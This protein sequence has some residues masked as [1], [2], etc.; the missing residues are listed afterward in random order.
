MP[1]HLTTVE[2]AR[3]VH[4][5][6]NDD[7][8]YL[9]NVIDVYDRGAVVRAFLATIGEVFPH[10]YLLRW[11]DHRPEE[12]E[13]LVVAGA[14]GPLDLTAFRDPAVY[15]RRLGRRVST[16][17]VEGEALREFLAA[18]QARILRDDHAPIDQ[19]TAPLFALRGD[20][21]AAGCAQPERR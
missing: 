4:G 8:V 12:I 5:L 18:G 15:H 1:Y 16:T 2:F 7:G 10:V 20:D 14:K 13:T 11:G 21:C 19:L 9:A 3:T 17:T 6:L